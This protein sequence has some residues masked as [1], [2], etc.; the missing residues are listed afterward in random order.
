MCLEYMERA[1]K[2]NE[3]PPGA[4]LGSWAHSRGAFQTCLENVFENT[5]GPKFA[6]ASLHFTYCF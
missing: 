5:A 1:P 2:T 4:L 3:V 6:T